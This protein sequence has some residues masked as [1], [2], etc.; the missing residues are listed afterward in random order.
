MKFL[1]IFLIKNQIRTKGINT[2][3][4]I[5]FRLNRSIW[6]YHSDLSLLIDGFYLELKLQRINTPLDLPLP[7]DRYLNVSISC[8]PPLKEGLGVVE[9]YCCENF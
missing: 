1:P 8:P 3:I 7:I 2:P 5:E 9:W 4:Y 6:N